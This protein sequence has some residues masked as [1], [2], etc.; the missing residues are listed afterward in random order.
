MNNFPKIINVFP[1]SN[2]I[3]FPNTT[4]PL[5]IFEPR[6]LDM[7]NDSMKSDKLIGMIQPKNSRDENDVPKLHHVGC[8]GKITSFRETEDGRYL[9]ELK[10]KIRFQ[11]INEIN[12]DKKYRSVEVDYNNYLDDLSDEKEELNFSDLELIFKDL[13]SLFE[14]RGFIINWKALEKQSLNETINA[15][16]MASPFSLEEKQILLEAKNL[17]IRKNKIAEILKTYIFDDYENTTLQ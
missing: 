17:D 2:F 4:V 13:K 11:I 12:T 6:Y 15:L 7:V 1:L 14:K 9:I 5:N 3:I 16:A 10:G 8:L